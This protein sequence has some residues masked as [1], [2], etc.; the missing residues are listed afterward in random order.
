MSQ[1]Q[2][3]DAERNTV[4]RSSKGQDIRERTFHFGVRI[5]KMVDRL[6]RTVAG[7]ALARQV[8]R[9]GTGIGANL[10]EAD[11]GESTDDFIHKM[12]ISLKEAQETRYW[13]RTILEA[14]LLTDDETKAL[15]KESDELVRI[16]NAI[17]KNTRR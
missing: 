9:S 2:S 11:A 3:A 13:L 10:E 16:I 7:Y 17:I 6:P 8:I 1:A 4:E 5:V 12:K 14:E 15:L